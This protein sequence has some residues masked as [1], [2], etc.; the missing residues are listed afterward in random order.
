MHVVGV[1]K[2][3]PQFVFVSQGQVLVSP[4]FMARYGPRISVAENADIVPR[5]GEASMGPLPHDVNALVARGSPVLDANATARRVNTTLDVETTALFL[6]AAAVFL[7][8]GILIAEVLGRSPSPIADDAGTLR[9]LGI[10]RDHLGLA[11]GLSH[12]IP[13]AVAAPVAFGGALLGSPHFPVGLGRRID[14]DV[15]YHVDWTIIGPGMAL[16]IALVLVVSVLIG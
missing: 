4:G 9:A 11:T 8:R 3:A 1:V 10:S 12:L 2:E 6:L 16:V 7:G 15:G 5:H 14:P 13:A